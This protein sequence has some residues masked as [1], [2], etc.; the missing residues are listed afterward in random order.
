MYKWMSMFA[1]VKTM[2]DQPHMYRLFAEGTQSVKVNMWYS[3]S[4]DVTSFITSIFVKIGY[5]NGSKVKRYI[6]I[7][8]LQKN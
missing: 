3:N 4:T 1:N 2:N 5:S 7:V 8:V 6:I